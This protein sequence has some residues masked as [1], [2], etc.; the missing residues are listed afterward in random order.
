MTT[1]KPESGDSRRDEVIAGEYV[2]GVLSAEDRRKAEARMATDRNF[3]AMVARWQNN[4]AAFGDPY[5]TVAP[6][7]RYGGSVGRGAFEERRGAHDQRGVWGSLALW[8]SLA[9]ASLSAIV[10]MAGAMAGLFSSR[11]GGTPLVANLESSGGPVNLVL[12]FEPDTGRLWL[13]PTAAVRDRSLE[14][15][16]TKG[17][18]APVSLGVLLPPSEGAT[19]LEP[20][21]RGR[22]APGSRLFVSV[23]PRGG[24]PKGAPTGAVIAQ[25]MARVF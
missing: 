24:S 18:D 1:Q 7:R 8:R 17:D 5:E 13:S 6:R 19:V 11:P 22:I 14:L 12:H 16:L 4:L 23:E 15:W 20:R 21:L 2:L 10:V 9:L 25:G 3:A